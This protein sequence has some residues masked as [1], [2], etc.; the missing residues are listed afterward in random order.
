MSAGRN[1][2]CFKFIAV[3]TTATPV[4]GTT[5]TN[6]IIGNPGVSQTVVVA[7]SSF[8]IAGDFVQLVPA[9]GGSGGPLEQMVPVI[10]VTDSTHIVIVFS[11]NHNAGDFVVL[12]WPMAQLLLTESKASA[13]AGSLFFGPTQDVDS[14]GDASFIDLSVV[15]TFQTPFRGSDSDN[16]CNYWVCGTNAGDVYAPSL[17]ISQ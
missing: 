17:W 12:F 13:P 4:V 1:P 11:G 9:K 6:N 5:L 2:R 15:F 16:I 14:S 7:D 8:F 10:S 3:A